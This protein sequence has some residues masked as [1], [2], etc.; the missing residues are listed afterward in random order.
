MGKNTN[1]TGYVVHPRMASRCPVAPTRPPH[2][3]DARPEAE[4]R[5]PHHCELKCMLSVEREWMLGYGNIE[6]T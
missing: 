6:W 4:E 3:Y 2:P 5:V 1:R